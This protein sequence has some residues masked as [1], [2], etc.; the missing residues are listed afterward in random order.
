MPESLRVIVAPDSFKGSMSAA[1]AARS[2]SSGWLSE[3]PRDSVRVMPQADGGEGTLAVLGAANP[4]AAWLSAGEVAGPDGRPVE[5]RWLLLSDGTAVVELAQMCGITL[6]AQLDPHRAS[7][8]GFGQVIA[9]ALSAGARRLVLCLGGSASNDGGVGAMQALGAELLDVDG[10]PIPDGAAGLHCVQKVRL[11]RIPP[12]PVGGVTVLSD[13]RA[14]L[15]GPSGA[16]AVFGKQ[17]GIPAD[18]RDHFESGM[19]ALARCLDVDPDRPGMGAAGGTAFG[20]AALWDLEVVSGA[21]FVAEATG[22][23]AAASHADVLVTGEGRFDS[24]S[25]TG[26][27]VGHAVAVARRHRLRVGV[28]AGAIAAPVDG[29]SI[30]LE[31]LAGSAARSISESSRYATMAGAALAR[32]QSE[33]LRQPVAKSVPPVAE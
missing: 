6:M 3:R 8:R 18:E 23:V 28:I 30:A 11:D 26:K 14:P 10:R 4:G 33:P 16:T 32:M 15:L 5:G 22:L 27:V 29:D 19:I 25:A 17:K 21:A 24:Q 1:E 12:M 31:T 13:V 20:L 7:T 9:A 2:I